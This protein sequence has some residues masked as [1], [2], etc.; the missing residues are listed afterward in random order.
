MSVEF[1]PRFQALLEAER[2]RRSSRHLAE[3][4]DSP[5]SLSVGRSGDGLGGRFASRALDGAS[6]KTA[7]VSTVET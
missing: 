4:A 3:Q 2:Q 6:A 7:G 1:D 5:G